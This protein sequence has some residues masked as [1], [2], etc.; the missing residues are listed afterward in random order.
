VE[1]QE[2]DHKHVALTYEHTL[3]GDLWVPSQL[4]P[5]QALR[6][7]QPLFRKLDESIVEEEI[8]RLHQAAAE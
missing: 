3:E 1:F 5:G 6:K 8:A 7:P 2:N 4:P